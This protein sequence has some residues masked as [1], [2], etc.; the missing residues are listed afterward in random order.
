MLEIY[1]DEIISIEIIENKSL[2]YDI[3]V[4][5]NNNFFANDILVHNCQN[6]FGDIQKKAKRFLTEKVWNSDTQTLE[7]HPVVIP[8][9]FKEPTY[10]VTMKL[11]GC[12]HKDTL[13]AVP[14]GSRTISELKI[15]DEILSYNHDTEEYY[16]DVV[17]GVLIRD[18]I[19]NWFEI[20]LEDDSVIYATGDHRFWVDSLECYRKVSDLVGDEIFL[21]LTQKL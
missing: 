14:G 9:D 13:I 19:D 11:D 16:N 7:E 3:T 6:I 10:E 17:T 1:T 2:R 8:A 12:L 15:G 20:I 18:N 5:D 21:Q 4:E